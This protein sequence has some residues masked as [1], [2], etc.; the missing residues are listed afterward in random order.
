MTA[1]FVSGVSLCALLIVDICCFPYKKGSNP[2]AYGSGYPNAAPT[3]DLYQGAPSGQ[4]SS[5]VVM[6]KRA[7]STGIPTPSYHARP[8]P[9]PSVPQPTVQR[10]APSAV[11]SSSGPVFSGYREPVV[12]SNPASAAQ[13]EAAFQPGTQDMNWA[14]H[15]LS[16]G[17]EMSSGSPAV[18]S[19]Y[20]ELDPFFPTGPMYQAGE[21]SHFEKSFEHGDNERETEEQGRL[22][23][24]PFYEQEYAGQSFTSQPQQHGNIG[25]S[26]GPNPFPGPY[27]FSGPYPYFDFMFMTGQ[28]PPGTVSHASNSYEQ[29]RDYWEDVH[30]VR[31]GQPGPQ[32]QMK[33]DT[34]DFAAP[35]SVKDPNPVMAGYG[36]AG[37]P[38][39]SHG[40]F[41]QPANRQAGGHNQVKVS[42]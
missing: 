3:L 34:G 27:P 23:P 11:S 28:Y 17:E 18:S 38:A 4:F 22:S 7:P 2:G 14:P 32:Q 12:R 29:G 10:P 19:L 30:Y 8:Q 1:R 20:E 26:W 16:R 21:L 40:G 31:D 9:G 35:Q 6:P 33:P 42:Y 39:S 24:P 5:E 15:S 25:E 41:R 13:P 37:R 36:Q